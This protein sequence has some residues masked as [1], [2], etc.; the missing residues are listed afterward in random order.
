MN[1]PLTLV[2]TNSVTNTQLRARF[3]P[4][5]DNARISGLQVRRRGDVFSDADGIPDWWRRA[6]FG[7]PTGQA[8]DQSRGPDDPDGDGVSNLTEY[9]MGTDPLAAASAP[10]A[11]Q[12]SILK[13]LK[14]GTDVQLDLLSVS[15]WSY[16]LQR[17]DRLDSNPLWSNIGPAVLSTGGVMTL[18]DAGGA[19]GGE[20]YYRVQAQ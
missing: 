17:R 2:F 14:A 6:Y 16:Q 8:A 5:V 20:K 11:P 12:F 19:V 1:R 18:N 9:R 10:A 15:N 4:V 7:H 3:T 13:I